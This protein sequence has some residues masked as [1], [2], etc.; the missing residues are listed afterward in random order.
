MRFSRTT[1]VI[2]LLLALVGLVAAALWFQQEQGLYTV[3]SVVDGDT[4]VLENGERVRYLGID[5]PETVH[6]SKPVECYGPEASARNKE[7]VEGKR[8][9][10]ESDTTDRDQYGRLLRYVYVGDTLVNAVLV[11][12]GYAYSYYYPP[13]TQRYQELAT[14]E[15]EAKAQGR[16]LWSACKP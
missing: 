1:A 15:Q 3:A 16:G 12:E 14:L 13:D 4:I 10:L 11:Q 9:R 6:P 8:V 2:V 5:T 7:L